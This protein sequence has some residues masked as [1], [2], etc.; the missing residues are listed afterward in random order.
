MGVL[1]YYN[2]A[3]KEHKYHAWTVVNLWYLTFG[4]LLDPWLGHYQNFIANKKIRILH[5][6]STLGWY[7]HIAYWLSL[8]I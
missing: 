7:H 8:F 3:T 2:F 4:L 6:F 1:G 5:K